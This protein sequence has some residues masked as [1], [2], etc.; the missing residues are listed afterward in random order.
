MNKDLLR[1]EDAKRITEDPLFKE[2]MDKVKKEVLDLWGAAGARDTEGR[3]WLWLMYQ[4]TLRFENVFKTY[5]ET[6][7][8]VDLEVARANVFQRMRNAL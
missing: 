7:R 6:G 3:E 1:A 4:A 2:A 5:L 8:L